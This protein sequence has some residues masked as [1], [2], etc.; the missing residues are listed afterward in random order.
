MEYQ[1]NFS[2]TNKSVLDYKI[3]IKKAKKTLVVI[4]DYFDRQGRKLNN[5]VCLDIGGSAGYIAKCLSTYVGKVYVIDIDNH[6]LEYGKKNNTASNIFYKVD[7]AMNLNFKDKSI[8]IIICN[9]VYEH[10]T[11]HQRLINEIDRVLKDDGICYF[12]ANNRFVLIEPHYKLPFL[13]WLPKVIAHQY[14]KKFRGISYYYENHLSYFS[15]IKLL[16]RFKINDYTI[17]VIK[18]PKTYY[19]NDLIK[20]DSVITKFPETILKIL[21]P[22]MRGYIF[23]LSK[24]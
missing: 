5:T 11:N 4:K 13:S 7:D 9:Q 19:A 12:G 8:D 17:S 1:H 16:N 6:A 23:I 21:E 2:I 18:D 10:I 3:R 20:E 15:L 24:K 14:L 22:I